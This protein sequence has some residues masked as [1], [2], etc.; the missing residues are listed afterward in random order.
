[1]TAPAT[2]SDEVRRL[3]EAALTPL[4]RAVLEKVR[5]C[6]SSFRRGEAARLQIRIERKGDKIQSPTA[7]V[8]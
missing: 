2:R 3:V 5:A 8:T 7:S 1:M 6:E 4:E